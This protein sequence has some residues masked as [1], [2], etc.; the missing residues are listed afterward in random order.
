MDNSTLV[1]KLNIKTSYTENK[2]KTTMYGIALVSL[3]NVIQG[4]NDAATIHAGAEILNIGINPITL[5]SAYI[6]GVS[7]M[8]QKKRK[9]AFY[10]M[11]KTGTRSL[12]EGTMHGSFTYAL[13]MMSY[14]IL[15]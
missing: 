7:T 2:I 9:Y 1:N 6:F 4:T 8:I 13:G 14:I 10:E 3:I 5:S 11:L 15:S 12:I